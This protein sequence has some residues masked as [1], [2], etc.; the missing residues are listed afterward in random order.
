MSDYTDLIAKIRDLEKQASETRDLLYDVDRERREYLGRVPKLFVVYGKGKPLFP[1]GCLFAATDY[2]DCRKWIKNRF[3]TY[4][5][6]RVDADIQHL[7][8]QTILLEGHYEGHHNEF[9]E[10]QT[11]T[12]FDDD[13]QEV[14]THFL[15]I[16]GQAK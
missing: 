11:V 2:A 14:E 1:S 6:G 13:W 8:L 9:V 3:E 12:P 4:L 16:D 15:A 10:I 7:I 5:E